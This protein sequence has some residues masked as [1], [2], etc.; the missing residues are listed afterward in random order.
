VGKQEYAEERTDSGLHVGHE[1]IQRK[2]RPE[3]CL[4]GL[5]GRHL[6]SSHQPFPIRAVPATVG[7]A[8]DAAKA[9]ST[10]TP[11]MPDRLM[12]SDIRILAMTVTSAN[13]EPT[14]Y[15]KQ[16]TARTIQG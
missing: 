7:V 2:Q 9:S 6:I 4:P 1:E 11:N 16:R 3:R 8:P 10:A 5:D 14:V 15:D 12:M 13:A